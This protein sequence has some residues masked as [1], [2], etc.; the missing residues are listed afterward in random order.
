MKL[1]E[2]G[3]ITSE[4]LQAYVRNELS[5]GDKQ[6][7]EKLLREDPFAQEALEGLQTSQANIDST[8]LNVNR[9][10]R[11]RAGIKEKKGI[12]IHWTNYA[13]AAVVV[14][15][16]IG[17][18]FVMINYMSKKA[19]QPIALKTPAAKEEKPAPVAVTQ[20]LITDSTKPAKNDTALHAAATGSLTLSMSSGATAA[21]GSNQPVQKLAGSAAPVNRPAAATGGT[22]V[23]WSAQPKQANEM[24]NKGVASGAGNAPATLFKSTPA[25]S[26]P[27]ADNAAS[28]DEATKNFNSGD[29]KKA[30][31]EYDQIL[32]RDP[33]NVDALY[34]GAISDY[35]DNKT[36]KSETQLDKV[37]KKGA[38]YTDG[39]KWYKANIL[40]KKG[41][42]EH[43]K[44]L[45]QELSNSNNPYRERAIKKIAEMGF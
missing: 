15:L 31:E 26:A 12:D 14:G 27:A 23:A 17:I 21:T 37:I 18:G 33:E 7:L 44:P 5:A 13:W 35:I 16:L 28:L 34:F 2:K 20:Q 9:K 45:L 1:S 11:E 25:A 43:A 4:A 30:G 24:T 36:A 39:A 41:D 3:I 38:K 22:S 40:L 10:V 29:Y 8:I 32:K 19:A 6:E 42:L